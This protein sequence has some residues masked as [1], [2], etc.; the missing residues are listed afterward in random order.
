MKGKILTLLCMT[1]LPL[2]SIA[3]T[4]DAA[5]S[6]SYFSNALFNTLLVVIILLAVM[7]ITV[8]R[9]LK[10]IVSSDF[11]LEKMKKD[12][13][14]ANNK[15]NKVAGL[16]IVFSLLSVTAFSQAAPVAAVKAVASDRIG[17]IDQFTF[18]TL[19]VTIF[20]ELVTLFLLFSTFKNILGASKAKAETPEVA[21][22]PLVQSLFDKMNYT[23]EL[24][25]EGSILLDH[26]YDGIKE[27]DN[28]LPPWWKYGFYLT[29]I[30]AFIY[31]VN[32]HI[33]KTSPL[34]GEEYKLS[35]KKAEADIA[36]Y[37]KTS[38]NNVD[39]TSVKVLT[40]ATEVGKGKEIF[41]T[42]CSPCHGKFGEG[43]VGPNLTDDYWIHG[44][45][46]VDIF[47]TIK[48]GWPEK[49]MK[50]WKEDFSPIQIQQV[51]SFIR[52][53]KGTNPPKPK[54]KQGDLYVEGPAPAPSDSTAIKKDSVSVTVTAPTVAK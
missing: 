7:V 50:S 5:T 32:F 11:F 20:L 10:N 46:I 25:D 35:M 40:D 33:T 53:L 34:Q 1:S 54:D 48:Y 36:E 9:A 42:T 4:T 19:V 17:G 24:E 41:L 18:Y 22:K 26:D 44:G 51:A 28:N 45:G 21:A 31:L 12:K 38:A 49:G 8:S 16:L 15:A 29:I 3:G 52:T 30:V 23:T 27:L 6:D 47:K 37:M 43:T 13:E 39:E 14:Q 2:L